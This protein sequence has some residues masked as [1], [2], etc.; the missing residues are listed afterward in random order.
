MNEEQITAQMQLDY[1]RLISEIETRM[2]AT[3]RDE[4]RRAERQVAEAM[5]VAGEN[6]E[7]QIGYVIGVLRDSGPAARS[8]YRDMVKSGHVL[9]IDGWLLRNDK[10]EP[11]SAGRLLEPP[12]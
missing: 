1:V 5:R 9:T 12:R 8:N 6:M 2:R 10:R 3:V 4:M 11:G 7:A